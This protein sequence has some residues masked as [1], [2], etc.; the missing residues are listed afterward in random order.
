MIQA[1]DINVIPIDILPNQEVSY[2]SN[3]NTGIIINDLSWAWSSSNACFPETQQEKFSG[4]HVL[5]SGVIPLHSEISIT[6][7]PRD[8]TA[9]FSIYAYQVGVDNQSIVPNLQQSIRCEAYHK[10]D[11]PKYGKTQNHIRTLSNLVAT[12]QPYKLIIGVT[13]ANGLEDGEFTLLI[14]TRTKETV[15]QDK[16]QL[17]PVVFS[18]EPTPN[19]DVAYTG[20]LNQGTFIND[21]SWAWSSQN[22]CFPETQV[23]KFTG[24]HL[25]FTGIIPKYSEVT[26]TVIPTDPNANFSVY[27]YEVGVNDIPIVPNLPSCIRCEADH[28]WDRPKRGKTQDHTRIVGNLVA[29]NNPYRLIVGVTG[30][31]GLDD[32]EFTLVISTK[33]R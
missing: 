32:G 11:Y 27:A 3:L 19:Q 2:T 30:A 20:N 8:S 29:L 21:L 4:N 17:P 10:W 28:K 14:N 18:I 23:N 5:F 33:S 25:F 15:D 7:I 12:T 26:V 16:E 22:A 9:N 6:V 24:K 13:G 1:Q 31:E